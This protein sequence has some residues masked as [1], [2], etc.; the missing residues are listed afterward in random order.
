MARIRRTNEAVDGHDT[1]AARHPREP[2]RDMSPAPG[3]RPRIDRGHHVHRAVGGASPQYGARHVHVRGDGPRV[4]A[5]RSGR[6]QGLQGSSPCRLPRHGPDRDHDHRAAFAGPLLHGTPELQGIERRQGRGG[7]RLFR[8]RGEA[9]GRIP[10]VGHRLAGLQGGLQAA[11][12]RSEEGHRHPG[13]PR[14]DRSRNAGRK[15]GRRRSGSRTEEL[16]W[17]EDHHPVPGSGRIRPR[18]TRSTAKAPDQRPRGGRDSVRP[19][20]RIDPGSGPRGPELPSGLRRSCRNGFLAGEGPSYLRAAGRAC[21]GVHA[22]QSDDRRPAARCRDARF[23]AGLGH[24][25]PR[26][27]RRFAEGTTFRGGLPMGTDSLPCSSYP[28]SGHRRRGHSPRRGMRVRATC[29]AAGGVPGVQR[30]RPRLVP[31][32]SPEVA[33]AVI[34]WG[35]GR[36]KPWRRCT[37]CTGRRSPLLGCGRGRGVLSGVLRRG[38]GADAFQARGRRPREQGPARGRATEGPCESWPVPEP[39]LSRP[40][41]NLQPVTHPEDDTM[42][43]LTE[44]PQVEA[45]KDAAARAVDRLIDLILYRILVRLRGRRC[46]RLARI[47]HVRR[48]HG[49]VPA[50]RD[51][52]PARG[53]PPDHVPYYS[54]LEFRCARL[55][56]SGSPATTQT[57]SSGSRRNTSAGT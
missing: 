53:L 15:P 29:P 35:A 22:D 10:P 47:P 7:R 23:E 3:S 49:R 6:V 54:F 56:W 36:R 39:T 26:V 12:Q 43:T 25:H 17:E 51:L 50:G 33:C 37:P 41:S 57:R 40:G 28:P 24:P 5:D 9:H 32:A 13:R 14:M 44:F 4:Q 42:K 1:G 20:W 16:R 27:P 46:P 45:A 38:D 31:P 52:P 21:R 30:Q 8:G 48:D 19:P 18:P 2:Q 11:R 34:P 55:S